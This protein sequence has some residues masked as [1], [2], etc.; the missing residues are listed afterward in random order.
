MNT[1]AHEEVIASINGEIG[2]T[3]ALINA[4]LV[5]GTSTEKLRKR[6]A[7]LHSDLKAA[8]DREAAGIAEDRA[9]DEA[10]VLASGGEIA[11]SAIASINAEL[12]ALAVPYRVSHGDERFASLAHQLARSLRALQK[13]VEKV[14]AARKSVDRIEARINECAARR[15]AI[16][17]ARLEGRSNDREANE[18]VALAADID[19]LNGLLFEARA[20]LDRID[21]KAE[22]A[23]VDTLRAELRQVASKVTIDATREHV[24]HIEFD[25][26]QGIRKLYETS[27]KHAPD[28]TS[29][30]RSVYRPND[31]LDFFFRTG[32]LR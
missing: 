13:V 7:A 24:A 27:R 12:E 18:F 19:A 2:E 10:F 31:D 5:A 23:T 29:T 30:P 26:L 3:N 22:K 4:A 25:L 11:A 28:R 21:D 9:K 17:A 32:A 1:A 20:K 15:S 8:H 16:T 6:L 14:D